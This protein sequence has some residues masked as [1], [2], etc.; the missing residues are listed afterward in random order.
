[1]VTDNA[2]NVSTKSIELDID[3]V[4]P[5]IEVIYDNDK[6]TEVVNGKGYFNAIRTATIIVTE[7]TK[8]FD[9]EAL[10]NQIK[11]NAKD[12]KGNE[13][14]S[15][16]PVIVFE[17]TVEGENAEKAQ[18]IFKIVYNADANY[19]FDISYVD[20]AGWKCDSSKVDYG[21]SVAPKNF[22]V[23][24][25]VPTGKITAGKLGVWESLL[26]TITFGLWSPDEVEIIITSDDVT[27]PI[28]KVE[29][30]KTTTFTALTLEELEAATTWVEADKLKVSTDDIFVVYARITDMSGNMQ[31]ISTNGIIVDDTKPVFETFSPEITITPEYPLNGIYDGNVRVDVSV[32]DPKMG[33]NS[34]YSGIRTIRYEV[35]SMGVKTQEGTLYNFTESNP[36]HNKLL[37]KWNEQDIVIV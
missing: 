19:T 22:T 25:V 28:K 30:Y 14:A 26:Q 33:E 36:T 11:I 5:T 32:I 4:A 6:A 23:D 17:K 7:R 1:M 20:K 13:L 15:A 27:S 3:I 12:A 8:H 10:L 2:G 34:A 9:K 18:H 21:T 37:Q 16:V 29:Y 35:Y 31:Y 24:T